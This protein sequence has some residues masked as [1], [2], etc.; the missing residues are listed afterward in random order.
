M[1]PSGTAMTDTEPEFRRFALT[2]YA[3]D[4]VPAATLFVQD[5]CEIDVNVLLLAA[6]VG[7]VRG[8]AFGADD[9][10]AAHHRVAAWQREVVGPLRA[11]RRRLKAGPPPAPS[12]TTVTLRDRVKELELDAELLELD[13]LTAFVAA[14]EL[15]RAPGDAGQRAVAAMTVV[16]GGDPDIDVR[17]A[18]S[19]IAIAA[20]GAR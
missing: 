7:A 2:V 15:T 19:T 18:I 9:L 3:C 14:R 12:P 16:V 1:R 6:Y 13:E 17:E 5:R 20:A 8:C 4:G 11:V 10:S